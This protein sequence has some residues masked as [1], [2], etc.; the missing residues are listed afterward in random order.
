MLKDNI[1]TI[2]LPESFARSQVEVVVLRIATEDTINMAPIKATYA[3]AFIGRH[4]LFVSGCIRWRLG[5]V[6]VILLDTA[7]AAKGCRF[8]IRKACQFD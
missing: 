4:V 3:L 8:L 2:E 7:L 6:I 5:S 1:L